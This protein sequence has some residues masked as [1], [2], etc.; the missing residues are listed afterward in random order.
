[1]TSL[2]DIQG[3]YTIDSAHSN[4]GFVARHAMITKVRGNFAEFE[5]T[6][7]GNGSAPADAKVNV[8]AKAASIYTGNEMRDKHL[9][10]GDFFDVEKFPEVKFASTKIDVIGDDTLNIT[11]DLTIRDQTRSITIPFEFGGEM[12]D[13]SGNSRIGF[14]GSTTISRKDFGLTWNAALEAGGVMVSDK[15]T[16][17]IEIS[18]VK[19]N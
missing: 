1:M 15:I 16:L 4:L 10:S 18:A 7:S 11:G 8:T 19:Q 6:A 9:R 12:T 3:N 17:E 14:E 2:K 13:A 5:G